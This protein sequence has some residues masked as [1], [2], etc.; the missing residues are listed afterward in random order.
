MKIGLIGIIEGE[1]ARD[2]FGACARVAAIGYQGME[3]GI[4]TLE[5]APATASEVKQRLDDLGLQ[6]VN[7]HVI[8]LM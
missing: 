6:I 5:Q 3:F 8:Y 4:A 1:L 7:I 2:F